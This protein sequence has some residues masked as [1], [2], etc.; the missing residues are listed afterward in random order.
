[1]KS[2]LNAIPERQAPLLYSARN[3]AKPVHFFYANRNAK[4]VTLS[5]DFN[6]WHPSAHPMRQRADG[7]WFIEV[8]LTRGHHHYLF[9]VDGVPTVDPRASGTA[10]IGPYSKAS[11]IAVG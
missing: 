10:T 3:M 1:M 7:W 4:S 5:G 9:L 6:V 11:L 2:F 8:L